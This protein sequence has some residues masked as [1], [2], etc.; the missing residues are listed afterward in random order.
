M[1][2]LAMWIISFCIV[3]AVPALIIVA[4]FQFIAWCVGDT[5]AQLRRR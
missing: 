2:Y 1:I 5:E 3:L 4:F